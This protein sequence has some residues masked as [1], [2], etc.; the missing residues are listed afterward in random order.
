MFTVRVDSDLYLSVLLGHVRSEVCCLIA[1]RVEHRQAQLGEHST[2]YC[3]LLL[4][5]HLDREA[6]ITHD[7][8]IAVDS[9]RIELHEVFA[10]AFD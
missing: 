6:S 5:V 1:I 7:R 3:V 10:T 2:A 9:L 8:L 4:N